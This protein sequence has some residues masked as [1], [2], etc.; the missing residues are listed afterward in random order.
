MCC[1]LLAGTGHA[2]PP[3][4][5]Q[6]P[7]HADVLQ[8]EGCAQEVP[9]T[10]AASAVLPSSTTVRLDVLVVARARDL[11][12]VRAVFAAAPRAYRPL[13]IELVPRFRTVRAV[14]DLRRDARAY[15]GWVKALVGGVRPAGTDVVYLAVPHEVDGAGIADCIGGIAH[16]EH[17]FAVGMLTFDGI[18]GVGITGSPVA[19]P[20]APL[21][22]GGAKLAAHEIGHL[23]GAH[24]HYGATCLAPDPDDLRHPCDVM[25][26]LP[27]Q[28]LGLRFGPLNAAV[29]REQALAFARP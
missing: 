28:Q 8:H 11:P 20:S 3:A 10:G 21:V 4:A 23:L 18:I 13:G 27:R 25:L 12:V 7:L 14:P 9:R 24:H 16:R 17:A 1:A 29:V 5:P 19:V 26:T 6:V 15:L 2:A 22:D